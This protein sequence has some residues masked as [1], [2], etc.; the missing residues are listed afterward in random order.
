MCNRRCRP[1]CNAGPAGRLLM[2]C[3]T[4]ACH[5]HRVHGTLALLG[6][7]SKGEQRRAD[8]P[9]CD[10]HMQPGQEGAL[11]GQEGLG[12]Q[13]LRGASDGCGDSQVKLPLARNFRAAAARTCMLGTALQNTS[14]RLRAVEDYS[15]LACG[16]VSE[17]PPKPRSPRRPVS[18]CSAPWSNSVSHQVLG[19]HM[20]A[21]A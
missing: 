6:V 20:P 2:R 4:P 5:T 12:L 14:A 3:T 11:A 19:T 1:P 17:G 18:F 15:Q 7:G 9:Q 8:R 13:P 21:A 16:T 10:G